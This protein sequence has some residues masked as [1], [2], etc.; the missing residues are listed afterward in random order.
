[1]LVTKGSAGSCL[2]SGY[3][4]AAPSK[5]LSNDCNQ[6]RHFKKFTVTV[7]LYPLFLWPEHIRKYYFSCGGYIKVKCLLR[8]QGRIYFSD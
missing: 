1:M 5:T 7:F 6:G 8:D 2:I 3:F 4:V